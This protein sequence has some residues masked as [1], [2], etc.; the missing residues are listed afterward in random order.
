MSNGPDTHSYEASFIAAFIRWMLYKSNKSFSFETVMSHSSKLGELIMAK[1]KGYRN[2]L[3]FVCID[4]PA[5]NVERVN[6][7]VGKGGHFVN[8]EKIKSR[9][10]QTLKNLFPAIKQTYR[11][12]LFDNSGKEPTLIAE[13]FEGALQL[14]VENPPKW[15][16]DY[17]LPNFE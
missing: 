17:V 5:V 7:R 2:Y 6:N 4:N 12:F 14:K 15:F 1:R 11:S 13:V 16:V 9:Y 8:E 10:I 3:Y